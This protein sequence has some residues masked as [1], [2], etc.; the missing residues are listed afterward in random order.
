MRRT[1]AVPLLLCGLVLGACSSGGSSEES[2]GG[3][4]SEGPTSSPSSPGSPGGEPSTDASGTRK[5]V[6]SKV[7]A[8]INAF[9]AGDFDTTIEQFRDA[10]PLAS[11][12]LATSP[13]QES[14][15]LLRAV[16]YYADLPADDYPEAARSSR[17]FQRWKSVTLTLCASGQ[18]QLSPGPQDPEDSAIPA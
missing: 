7:V 15:L 11:G 4:S 5:A 10:V 6:C 17:D 16:R 9:N 1:L 8:G 12:A 2:L 14:K 18:D 3:S 13:S